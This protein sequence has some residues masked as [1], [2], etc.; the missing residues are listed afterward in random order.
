MTFTAQPYCILNDVKMALDPTITSIDDSWL[1]QLISEAQA[2]LDS[3]IGYS[4]QQDGTSISPATRLYDGMDDSTSSN[5]APFTLWIDDLL[6]LYGGGACSPTPCGAVLETTYNT[7]LST[8]GVWVS[9]SPITTDITADIILKPN[10]Y[11]SLGI[12]AHRMVRNSGLP[13]QVGTQN[14][15]VMGVFGR[16]I[17]PGQLY[18]GVPN[19]I[20]R[21]CIRLTIHYYK[22]RD[23]NYANEMQER[24]GIRQKYVIDW[25]D[26]VMRIVRKYTHRRFVT[27]SY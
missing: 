1:N 7:F 11:A 3:E 5:T 21:A 19:D 13:F 26:D 12:P 24:G 14:Y 18:P 25:P 20:T 22:M 27:R 8:N 4:F 2:D 6:S 9:T 15:S 16:P 10:N 17:L 23:V